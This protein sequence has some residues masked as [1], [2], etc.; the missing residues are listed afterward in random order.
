LKAAE[1]LKAQS[2]GSV[3]I[4]ASSIN[5]PDVDTISGALKKTGGRLVTVED[6]EKIGGM[7]ALIAAALTN[8]GVTFK[9]KILGV[10]D[11]FGQSAY[12]AIELYRKHGL[13]SES[14]AGTSFHFLSKEH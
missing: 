7:G 5:H 13:D 9:G 10:S 12:N 1:L 3:V 14:I 8:A 4:N 6:H 2:I 11:A